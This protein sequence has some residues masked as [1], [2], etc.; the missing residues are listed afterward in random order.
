MK[1]NVILHE[2]WGN[3]FT[4][5]SRV[6][7]TVVKQLR[8]KTFWKQYTNNYTLWQGNI[9]GYSIKTGNLNDSVSNVYGQLYYAQKPCCKHGFWAVNICNCQSHIAYKVFNF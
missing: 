9:G 3:G 7:D 4:G 6:I 8:K 5:S 1:K 2:I